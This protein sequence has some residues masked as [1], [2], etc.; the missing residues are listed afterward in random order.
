M[1]SATPR[2]IATDDR[3]ATDARDALDVADATIAQV[4]FIDAAAVKADQMKVIASALTVF[5]LG[6]SSAAYAQNGSTYWSLQESLGTTAGCIHSSTAASS[7]CML[8]P[9]G[10]TQLDRAVEVTAPAAGRCCWSMARGLDIGTVG[11]LSDAAGPNGTTACAGFAFSATRHTADDRPMRTLMS[12]R[13]G[14]RGGLCSVAVTLGS[15]TLYAPC[16]V[17]SD[18]DAPYGGGTCT[19]SPSNT[20]QRAPGVHLICESDTGTIKFSVR[21]FELVPRPRPQ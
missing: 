16:T 9:A 10:P 8:F 19:A 4:E 11:T 5:I 15:D 14:Y 6:A 18:C 7:A 13:A 3:D 17:D 2:Q 20:Q 12:A 1:R 21:K